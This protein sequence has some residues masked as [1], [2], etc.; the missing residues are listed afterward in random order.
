MSGKHNRHEAKQLEN[1]IRFEASF[2]GEYAHQ[3]TEAI[4]ECKSETDL[5]DV[6]VSAFL[7]KYSFYYTKSQRPTPETKAMID[8]LNKKDF[9]FESPTAR[10]NLLA[11]S[12]DYLINSSGLFPILWKVNQIWG[13]GTDH[14]LLELLY[15]EYHDNFEP[16]DDHIAWVNKYKLLYQNEG[17]PWKG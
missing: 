16:N 8:L 13:K 2:R 4:K 14:E 9:K 15:Q 17:K 7:E 11:Q 6:L 5:K 12:I 1:W 3:L 10:N